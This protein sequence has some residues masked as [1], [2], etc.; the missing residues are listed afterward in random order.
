MKK[1]PLTVPWIQKKEVEI[2]DEKKILFSNMSDDA[3]RR[4]ETYFK[5]VFRRKNVDDFIK[6][7]IEYNEAIVIDRKFEEKEQVEYDVETID[8]LDIKKGDFIEQTAD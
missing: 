3:Y 1:F 8:K 2:Q 5:E 4:S 6:G 7:V